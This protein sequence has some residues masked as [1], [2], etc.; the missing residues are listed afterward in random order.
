MRVLHLTKATGISGSERHLLSLL[1]GLRARGI[2]P[3]LVVLAASGAASFLRAL[4]A[5]KI[6]VRAM[7]AGR[8]ANPLLV[9]RLRRCFRD[10]APDVV[11]T[12][13]IHADVHGQLAARLARMP[14]VSTIH[15]THRFYRRPP[16]RTA[17][18][19]AAGL[20]GRT[21]AISQ[22]VAQTAGNAGI[23]R[24]DQIR[25][26]PY[27]VDLSRWPPTQRHVARARL[28]LGS[29]NE[30]L[31]GVA[32]RL[33]PGKGHDVLI[34][35]A[36]E[37]L[38]QGARL[39]LLIAGNGPTRPQCE[40]L[41]HSERIA[42]QISF[43]GFLDDIGSFFAACDVVAFPSQPDFGEG[44]GLAALEAMAAGLPVVAT[45]VA[46]LPEIVTEG[47]TGV[48]TEPGDVIG[49]ADTLTKFA[50]SPELRSRLGASGRRR[51]EQHFSLKAMVDGTIEVYDEVLN[52]A[53]K[54][55]NC[56]GPPT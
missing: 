22:H 43:L 49:L 6:E 4:D 34:R 11:H 2:E 35:A 5:E 26:I 17:A 48:L 47:E 30:M 25:V 50:K 13:L 18:R 36:A 39:R 15:S 12:H 41:A 44:F 24:A 51:A 32:S 45:R 37:A 27:G 14:G 55:P 21:I 8:D 52:A 56:V 29:Q 42:S 19:M 16:F 53:S 23:A 20:A 3:Y 7:P 31:V 54:P 40:A 46:S 9:S 33:I 1:P 10:V 38:R 28:G